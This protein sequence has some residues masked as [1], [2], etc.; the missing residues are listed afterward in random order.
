MLLTRR[1]IRI[2]YFED[3][4]VESDFKKI[5]NKKLRST[6][7]RTGNTGRKPKD[8]RNGEINNSKI[9]KLEGTKKEHLI[10]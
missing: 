3:W 4:I 5:K 2:S 6:Y 9:T 10:P 1:E 7:I 8:Q